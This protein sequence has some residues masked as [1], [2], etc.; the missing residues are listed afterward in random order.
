MKKEAELEQKKRIIALSSVSAS[1][2]TTSDCTTCTQRCAPSG[3]CPARNQKDN[4]KDIDQEKTAE[5]GGFKLSSWFKN[6][7]GGSCAKMGKPIDFKH[8]GWLQ[9]VPRGGSKS[10]YNSRF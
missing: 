8:R 6:L 9:R 7:K 5:K 4:D 10:T 3:K 2:N 1:A